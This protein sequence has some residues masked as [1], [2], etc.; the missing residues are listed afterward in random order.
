MPTKFESDLFLQGYAIGF[1][2]LMDMLKVQVITRPV[3]SNADRIL[4]EAF[5]IFL[6]GLEASLASNTPLREWLGEYNTP[7][8]RAMLITET[9]KGCGKKL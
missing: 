6:S 4:G 9:L 3:R 5:T 2:H 7:E 1:M 8:M